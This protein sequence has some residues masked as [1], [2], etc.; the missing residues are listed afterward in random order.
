MIFEIRPKVIDN[1]TLI[2]P[3][4]HDYR[5][6]FPQKQQAPLDNFSVPP[7]KKKRKI[8]LKL[9]KNSLKRKMPLEKEGNPLKV[10]KL[11]TA[12]DTKPTPLH[13]DWEQRK[14][15][16]TKL[17]EHQVYLSEVIYF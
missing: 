9:K 6:I 17:R 1:P 13:S 15:I 12:F 4:K 3:I 14:Q 10:N 2:R 11:P 8:T 16:E 7:P 5:P